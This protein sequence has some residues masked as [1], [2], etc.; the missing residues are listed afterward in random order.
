MEVHKVLGPGSLE[1]VYQAALA[2]ELKLR[3]ASLFNRYICP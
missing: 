3:D 1:A 2:H